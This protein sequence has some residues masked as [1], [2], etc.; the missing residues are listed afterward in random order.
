MTFFFAAAALALALALAAGP[1]GW[2][3]L[4]SDFF[5]LDGGTCCNHLAKSSILGIRNASHWHPPLGENLGHDQHPGQQPGWPARLVDRHGEEFP[6]LA[7]LEQGYWE[8]THHHHW[9][10]QDPL[11]L[12]LQV[13]QFSVLCIWVWP[14][15]PHILFWGAPCHDHDLHQIHPLHGHILHQAPQH[16]CDP[17]SAAW[18]PFQRSPAEQDPGHTSP[19]CTATGRTLGVINIRGSNEITSK[20]ILR[21]IPTMTF[22]RFFPG[23]SSGILFGISSGILSGISSGDCCWRWI[24]WPK[25][26]A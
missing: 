6:R 17:C 21:V 24:C 8:P 25:G 7:P 3:G 1:F 20:K 22:I 13:P 14:P 11:P 5:N 4:G 10:I 19:T 9:E 12:S 26:K 18:P 15:I 16:P 23:K 2:S